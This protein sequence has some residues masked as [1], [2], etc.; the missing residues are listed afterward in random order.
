MQFGTQAHRS[1]SVA[2]LTGDKHANHPPGKLNER[3]GPP[4]SLYVGINISLFF[5]SL[6]FCCV[7]RKFLG[8]FSCDFTSGYAIS[9]YIFSEC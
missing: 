5:S 8:V 7:F 6:L 9:S 4:L 1:Q 3:T 2:L